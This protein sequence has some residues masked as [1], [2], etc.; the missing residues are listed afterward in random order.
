[1]WGTPPSSRTTVAPATMPA[2]S[3]SPVVAGNERRTSHTPP[4]RATRA[5]MST[6][7]TTRRKNRTGVESTPYSV[8]SSQPAATIVGDVI[9]QAL[10]AHLGGIDEIAIFV[11]PALAII[12][13]MRRSE[14]KAQEAVRAQAADPDVEA[15][16]G[17]H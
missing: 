15:A 8:C 17:D 9:D 10:L 12:F 4:P 1:M 7:A 3:T 11:V 14:R 6:N 2:T 5:T 13:F 16:P